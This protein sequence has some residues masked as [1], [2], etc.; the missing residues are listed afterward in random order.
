MPTSLALQTF[1]GT[2]PLIFVIV[3]AIW[4]N[5]QRLTELSKRIDDLSVALN[6][7]IDDLRVYIHSEIQRLEHPIVR[8]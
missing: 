6:K 3:M 7:R 2:I 4:I 1:Y 8:G 5:N